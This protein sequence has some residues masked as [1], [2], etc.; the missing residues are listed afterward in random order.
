M[1]FSWIWS[2]LYETDGS[3]KKKIVIFWGDGGYLLGSRKA[4]QQVFE[5]D[6]MLLVKTTN[7][8]ILGD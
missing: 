2:L 3:E 8:V 4:N 7:K 6:V 1:Q 5:D